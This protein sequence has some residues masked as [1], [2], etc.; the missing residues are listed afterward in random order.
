MV[1]CGHASTGKVLLKTNTGENGNTVTEILIDPQGLD[2]SLEAMGMVATFYV[3]ADGKNITVDY[4]ST[5][6]NKYYKQD[7]QYS[8]QIETVERA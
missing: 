6:H 8:F 1:I 3:S 7:N 4:Y 5:V 2:A